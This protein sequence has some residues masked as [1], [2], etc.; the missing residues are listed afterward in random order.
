MKK[1]VILFTF[2]F[3]LLLMIFATSCKKENSIKQPN[4]ILIMADDMGFS[5]MGA[6]GGEIKT[7]VLDGLA[8]EGILY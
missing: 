2:P 4:I 1:A 6:M 3:V 8:S 7:P 5:D